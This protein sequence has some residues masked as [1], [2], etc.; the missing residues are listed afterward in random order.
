[1]ALP[2]D[3]RHV[4]SSGSF[5]FVL[6]STGVCRYVRTLHPQIITLFS[7]LH[8]SIA[9]VQ[10][11]FKITP[12]RTLISVKRPLFNIRSTLRNVDFPVFHGYKQQKHIF[13][14]VIN[15][16]MSQCGITNWQTKHYA[17]TLKCAAPSPPS[18]M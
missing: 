7:T 16:T 3:S 11:S 17:V 8:K 5:H 6:F 14:D 2:I 4:S 9:K 13:I 15:V 12:P 18:R 10:R 1:M